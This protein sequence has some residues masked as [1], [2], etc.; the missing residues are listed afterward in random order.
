MEKI[1]RIRH[2]ADSAREDV[3]PVVKSSHPPV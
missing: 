2:D 1:V 3:V